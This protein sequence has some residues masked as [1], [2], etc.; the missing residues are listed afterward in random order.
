MGGLAHSIGP[1]YVGL[2]FALRESLEV[3]TAVPQKN[4]SIA[5]GKISHRVIKPL[6][7]YQ[8]QVAAVA[9]A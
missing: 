9:Q 5:P 7:M 4:V 6:C 8:T 3:L 2:C 1:G